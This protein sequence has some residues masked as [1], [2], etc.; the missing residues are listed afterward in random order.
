MNEE[1]KVGLSEPMIRVTTPICMVCRRASLV[2][3]TR[4]EFKDV[5]ENRMSIQEALPNRAADFRELVKSGTHHACW[6]S[7]TKGGRGL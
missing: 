4:Q 5:V 1:E 7:V 2:E 6:T 3:L